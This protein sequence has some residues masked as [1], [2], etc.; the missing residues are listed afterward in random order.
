MGAILLQLIRNDGGRVL[1]TWFFASSHYPIAA[2]AVKSFVIGLLAMSTALS[3]GHCGF[4][5]NMNGHLR[6]QAV[7]KRQVPKGFVTVEGDKFKLDGKDFYFAGSNAYY[8]PFNKVSSSLPTLL[9]YLPHLD[10]SYLT[11]HLS[12]TVF[13][14]GQTHC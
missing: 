14:S 3:L 10:I 1:D 12:P 9:P 5:G 11:G 6:R 2:M 8:F 7:T 13:S 4:V